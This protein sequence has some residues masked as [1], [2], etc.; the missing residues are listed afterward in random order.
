MGQDICWWGLSPESVGH[1]LDH[2]VLGLKGNVPCLMV[3]SCPVPTMALAHH[4][5]LSCRPM[6]ISE[7]KND[8]YRYCTTESQPVAGQRKFE[9]A[10]EEAG[11]QW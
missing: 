11:S 4:L 2:R 9:E 6:H 7:L 5:A 3:L 10:Q 8:K 1:G